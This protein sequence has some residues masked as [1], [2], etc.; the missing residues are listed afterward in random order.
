MAYP[1]LLIYDTHE[2]INSVI[3]FV[4]FDL[5]RSNIYPL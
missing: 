4:I 1:F 3:Y 2:V 5:K